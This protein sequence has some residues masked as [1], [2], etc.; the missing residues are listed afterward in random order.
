[1][2]FES[3]VVVVPIAVLATDTVIPIGAVSDWSKHKMKYELIITT[4][5]LT[6]NLSGFLILISLHDGNCIDK[7][8]TVSHSNNKNNTQNKL[9][10][11]SKYPD[12]P[13][14]KSADQEENFKQLRTD[15]VWSNWSWH[16][17]LIHPIHRLFLSY[18]EGSYKGY[19]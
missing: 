14:Q 4:S 11:Y 18:T 13:Q 19:S 12:F 2:D 9:L 6:L 17:N 8:A 5:V 15:Y 3:V 16:M 1:M 7:T 10:Y